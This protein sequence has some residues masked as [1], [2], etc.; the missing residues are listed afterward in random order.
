MADRP[1]EFSLWL[2][3]ALTGWIVP[4]AGLAAIALVGG[5]YALDVASEEATAGLAVAAVALGTALFIVKS[6]LAGHGVPRLLALAAAAATALAVLLPALPTVWPSRT[7]FEGELAAVGDRIPLPPEAAGKVRLLVAGRLREA[8]EP[9]ASYV[10][11]GAEPAVEGRLERT[12]RQV[13][14]GRGGRARVAS[15]H[16]ADWYDA[17]I[18]AGAPELTLRRLSGQLGGKLLV[19]GHRPLLPAP[20]PWVLSLL[21]LALAA[22]AEARLGRKNAVAVPAG[23]A[24]TFGLLVTANATPYTAVGPVLGAVALGAIVGSLGGWIAGIVARRLIHPD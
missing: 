18:P 6:A 22:L 20:W 24:L 12:Y 5:L 11:G 2:E 16:T 14:V 9:S 13:R 1:T 17:T 19:S 4:V 10:L 15:D 21:A 3:E 23:M 8:G 7:I